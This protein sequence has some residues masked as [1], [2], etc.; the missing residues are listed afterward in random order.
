MK[1]TGDADVPNVNLA[2][3]LKEKD[4]KNSEGKQKADR[5]NLELMNLSKVDSKTKRL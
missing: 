2:Y 4:D 1:V 5:S 3:Q